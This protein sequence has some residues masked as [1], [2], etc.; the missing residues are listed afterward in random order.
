MPHFDEFGGDEWI[1]QA[2]NHKGNRVQNSRVDSEWR[3]DI[4][5]LPGAGNVCPVCLADF[6]KKKKVVVIHPAPGQSMNFKLLDAQQERIECG[7]IITEIDDPEERLIQR[8]VRRA[9][10]NSRRPSHCDE[11]GSKLERSEGMVGE[12]VLICRVH[13]LKWEN[14]EDAIRRVI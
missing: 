2:P 14:I 6:N 7:A 8:E 11:C 13:G 12:E 3:P 10:G 1:C 9:G 5:G 4:T